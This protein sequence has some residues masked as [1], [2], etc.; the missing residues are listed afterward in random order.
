MNDL[1]PRALA[2][3]SHPCAA[4]SQR[5]AAA[6]GQRRNAAAPGGKGGAK[7]PT[8]LETMLRAARTA[9]R[10]A[11]LFA[12]G[13]QPVAHQGYAPWPASPPSRR[14]G[15]CAPSLWLRR[16]AGACGGLRGHLPA[17][18]DTDRALI[19]SFGAAAVGGRDLGSCCLAGLLLGL[20]LLVAQAAKES[21]GGGPAKYELVPAE[22]ESGTD[23]AAHCARCVSPD[24]GRDSRCIGEGWW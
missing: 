24:C 1:Q 16:P 20:S 10:G 12:F 9:K 13:A 21:K 18:G 8:A 14:A 2:R 6:A 11:S 15:A 7:L 3:I 17:A 22:R 5:R 4:A 23:S 19:G